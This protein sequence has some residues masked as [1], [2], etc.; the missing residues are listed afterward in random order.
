MQTTKR[1]VHL[2]IPKIELPIGAFMSILHRA[3][4]AIMFLALPVLLYL[5]DLSLTGPEG[6]QRASDIMHN[7]FFVLLTFLLLW[8]LM[9]HLLAGIR[10]L[11][12]DVHIGVDKPDF[13][14]S[15]QAVTFVAPVVALIL[16]GVV[17]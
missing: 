11:L 7:W 1:P 8:S 13:R 9:H 10:Y 4:G 6:Y 3:T 5:L 15:A 16:T 12:L 2:D 17:L 14:Q